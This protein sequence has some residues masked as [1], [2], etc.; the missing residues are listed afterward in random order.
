[1]TYTEYDLSN[2][3]R[4]PI[5]QIGSIQ[6]H[7]VL[8]AL[9]KQDLVIANCSS[10]ATALLG[11]EENE[12]VGISLAELVP[13]EIYRQITEAL[14]ADELGR[15]CPL[16]FC[17][18]SENSAEF[19]A[20]FYRSDNFLILEAEPFEKVAST[21]LTWQLSS[22]FATLFATSSI[23]DLL[24]VT[25]REVQRITD[26]DRVLLYQF[27]DD[28][29]GCVV[30]EERR[31]YMP[32]FQS[33]RFPASDIPIQARELYTRNLTRLLVDVNSQPVPI[34]PALNGDTNQPIDLSHSLLRSMSP[35]HIEYL[36][37]MDVTASMSISVI[38]DGKLWAL[39]ACHHKKPKLVDYTTRSICQ[40][41]AQV[42]S[43]IATRMEE[44]QVNEYSLALKTVQDK[45]LHNLSTKGD[46]V[47]GLIGSSSMVLD[48]IG[49]AGFAL[50]FE[51][52]VSSAGITPGEQELADLH[53]W[54]ND[55]KDKL[56][57]SHKLSAIYAPAKSFARVASGILAVQIAAGSG[58]WLVWFRPE[59]IE[60]IHWAGD[61]NKPVVMDE[62]NSRIHPRHSFDL[63]KEEVRETATP[64]RQSQIDFAMDLRT[65]ILDF[66]FG[67]FVKRY[68]AEEALH[69]QSEKFHLE[70]KHLKDLS[71]RDQLTGLFNR[72]YM[73]EFF[74]Q[75]LARSK[76]KS[77]PFSVLMIDIDF[78]KKFNDTFG[79]EAGDAVLHGIGAFLKKQ[80][81]LSDIICRFG[82]EEF[83]VLLPEASIEFAHKRAD[84]LRED[85][86]NLHISYENAQLPE[87]NI[88]IGLAAFPIHG[89]AI[90]EIIKAADEALYEAKAQ[91]R[92]RVC[93]AVH[94]VQLK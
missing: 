80:L 82:G 3:E 94:A 54:L 86:K 35:L 40:L 72:R 43:T 81:R 58:Y 84:Q 42:L 36:K 61:P 44:T 62:Q 6:P 64:W 21:D 24:Q 49:S 8:L 26:F 48:A 15:I 17:F 63:W 89:N 83:I 67:Q 4:E 91:G 45:L 59:I 60:E 13:P 28:W 5:H 16:T 11:F 31:D 27:D 47:D 32:S 22:T 23:S 39:I 14:L 46:L 90:D 87:I 74:A 2:C 55:G 41:L 19:Q 30:A 33:Q 73:E 20:I 53:T 71:I 18:N 79:H 66:V 92:D 50:F 37:N 12:I 10:N 77:T 70:R 52:R 25:V 69:K 7:G 34:V 65:N 29:N 93:V 85:V 76:R 78:F 9:N 38:R 51:G 1:M 88:S 56:V 57:C 75:E 68:K